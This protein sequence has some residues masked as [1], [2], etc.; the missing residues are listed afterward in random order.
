MD[1]PNASATMKRQASR[2]M[3]RRGEED[4]FHLTDLQLSEA[5]TFIEEIGFG[6][7]SV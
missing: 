2:G 3:M 4:T 6:N 5:Y 1:P 7:W